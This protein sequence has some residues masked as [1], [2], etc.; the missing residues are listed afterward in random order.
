VC[1][2]YAYLCDHLII[3]LIVCADV[4][5]Y[6]VRWVFSYALLEA[7]TS[8]FPFFSVVRVGE[9]GTVNI[10]CSIRNIAPIKSTGLH[11]MLSPSE[12]AVLAYVLLKMMW[13]K[14]LVIW[15][16]FRLWALADGIWVP[17][18]MT[19][20]MSNNCSLEQFWKGWH[21]SFNLWIVRCALLRASYLHCLCA[22][23]EW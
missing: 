18:N 5:V 9:C 20:C 17:E 8:F 11:N 13:L 3:C 21:A 6:F 12:M 2:K 19:R 4:G 23:C 14:F 16:F 22:K 15:R 10:I 1:N 7:M